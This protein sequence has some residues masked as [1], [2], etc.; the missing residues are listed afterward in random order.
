MAEEDLFS[1]V[2]I[3]NGSGLI[4]T[5]MSGD[6]NPRSVFPT[7]IGRPLEPNIMV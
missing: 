2:V 5:G 1:S 4:K 7:I 6:D 3:D